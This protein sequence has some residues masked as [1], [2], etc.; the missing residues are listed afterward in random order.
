MLPRLKMVP[1]LPRVT[2]SST[3]NGRFI[4]RSPNHL[5]HPPGKWCRILKAALPRFQ[6]LVPPDV[7][8]SFVFDQSVYVINAVKS[9]AEEGAI[10]AILTGLMVLLFLGDRRGAAIVI[11]TIP[12]C[13]ISSVFLPVSFPSNHQYHDAERAFAGHRYFGG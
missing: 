4:C 9:L 6:G 13:V 5:R 2:P 7:K 3:V 12:I 1:I 10:G 8:L 11:M